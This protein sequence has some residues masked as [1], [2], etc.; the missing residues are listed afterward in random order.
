M[1]RCPVAP[2][3]AGMRGKRG[4]FGRAALRPQRFLVG[5][6]SA[7]EC[8]GAVVLWCCDVQAT[9]RFFLLLS[10]CFFCKPSK[11]VENRNL[12]TLIRVGECPNRLVVLAKGEVSEANSPRVAGPGARVTSDN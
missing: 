5:R 3:G 2:R 8:G 11:P 1:Q 6:W 4:L 9:V 10:S 12:G 7:A